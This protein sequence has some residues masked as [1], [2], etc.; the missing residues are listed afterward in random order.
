VT[1]FL[2]PGAPLGIV[3]PSYS[4]YLVPLEDDWSMPE[5]IARRWTEA[6]ARLGIL[7]NPHAPSGRLAAA[8]EVA[9]IARAFEGV[10]VID[11]AYVD[12]VDPKSR[13]APSPWCGNPI[14]SCACG[15]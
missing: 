13:T 12:F 6:G 15:P 9:A 10:L 11:E 8:D 14:T 2:P 5:D 7:V 4:L 1:T 3:E